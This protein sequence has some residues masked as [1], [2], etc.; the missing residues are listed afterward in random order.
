MA[1]EILPLSKRDIPQAVECIQTV[2]ADDPFFTYMFDPDTYNIARNAASLSAHFH[3]GLAIRAPIYI[4]KDT[5]SNR[6]VGICWWHSPEPQSSRPPLSH[7]AQEVL[8]SIRRGGLRLHR[9]RQWKE[10]Q[11]KRHSRLWTDE[12]GYYFCNVIAV[13]AE[14]RGFGLGR[15][16]VEVVTEQADEEGI[17]CYL[18]SS[19][20]M[21]NLAI[22]Q[23]L[24][25][26]GVG[27]IEC[28]D[29]NGKDGCTLYC[30]IRQPVKSENNN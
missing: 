1:V 26:K 20:G 10:L 11:A 4:A 28:V 2:F 29:E 3:H 13:R 24:G 14:M 9:Y 30:M 23:K 22:Y 18:E 5:T 27:E 8:L 15:R 6:I 25:F 12:R 21:P 7:K 19:K 16:L 17:P